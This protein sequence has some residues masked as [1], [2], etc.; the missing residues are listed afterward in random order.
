MPTERS[1]IKTWV[2]PDAFHWFSEACYKGFVGVMR[3]GTYD[4][5]QQGNQVYKFY[6]KLGIYQKG[7]D[8]KV[9]LVE[10][11]NQEFLP[12]KEN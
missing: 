5:S 9:S 2:G 4:P 3:E 8:G 6:G 12:K 1:I 7:T 10:V 11:K